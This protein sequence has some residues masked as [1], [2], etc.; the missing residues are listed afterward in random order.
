MLVRHLADVLEV[1]QLSVAQDG[2]TVIGMREAIFCVAGAIGFGS[3]MPVAVQC[4]RSTSALAVNSQSKCA[5][6]AK[7]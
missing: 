6:C 5:S 2:T 3:T 1:C 4:T 7:F